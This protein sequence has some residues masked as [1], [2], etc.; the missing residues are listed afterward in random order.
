METT[1][2]SP[3]VLSYATSLLELAEEQ[4]IA[5]PIGKE[6]DQ[7]GEILEQNPTFVLYL[8]DPAISQESRA[9]LLGDVF[10]GKISP[11]LWNF[12]GVM[13]LKNRLSLLGQ[14]I[15]AYGDLLDDKFG[16][17]EVDV[18]T[19]HKLSK[20]ELENVRQR[21]GNALKRDAVIHEYVDESLIGGMMLRVQDQLIDASVKSQLEKIK[22]KLA[23][24][25]QGQ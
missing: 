23:R 11:L 12:I 3:V 1:H 15:T 21:V 4:K 17:I 13:N 22:Q 10:S 20:D 19:A 24:A 18:T 2:H 8:A 7:I 25:K 16:K 9:K 6:L 14:I 5:D